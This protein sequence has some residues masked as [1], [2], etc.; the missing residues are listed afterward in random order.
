[1]KKLS[2]FP[3]HLGG[4]PEGRVAQVECIIWNGHKS[5]FFGTNII[6]HVFDGRGV[7]VLVA[8]W[9]YCVVW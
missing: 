9:K 8:A 6:S 5:I 1:M 2:V 3:S 4:R 7:V